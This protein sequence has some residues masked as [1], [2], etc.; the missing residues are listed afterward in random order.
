MVFDVWYVLFIV[1]LYKNI[2][3]KMYYSYLKTASYFVY[4]TNLFNFLDFAIAGISTVYI[5]F[6]IQ[7]ALNP[8]KTAFDIATSSYS[9]LG[10]LG[11]AYELGAQLNAFN[12]FLVVLRIFEYLAIRN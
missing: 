9:E 3:M 7:N 1:L 8:E 4:F 2:G 5:T 10:T 6:E 11:A 12:A